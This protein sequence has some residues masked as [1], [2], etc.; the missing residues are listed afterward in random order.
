M[1]KKF[2]A[3]QGEVLDSSNAKRINNLHVW[4]GGAHMRGVRVGALQGC[5][6]RF[7]VSGA[8]DE[9]LVTNSLESIVNLEHLTD[10]RIF[11]LPKQSY[12]KIK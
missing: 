3:L 7:R 10:L 8:E 9:D 4:P 6:P 2:S 12:I 1:K 5:E 11:S